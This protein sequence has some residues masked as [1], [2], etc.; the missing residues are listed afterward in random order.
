VPGIVISPAVG[1]TDLG[2]MTDADV[3]HFTEGL[4]RL[5]QI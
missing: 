4:L 2:T 1:P 5:P 3:L